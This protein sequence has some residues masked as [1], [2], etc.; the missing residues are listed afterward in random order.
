MSSMI[1]TYIEDAGN[2]QRFGQY[3]FVIVS[4]EHAQRIKI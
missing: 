4:L 1:E 3:G 2:F